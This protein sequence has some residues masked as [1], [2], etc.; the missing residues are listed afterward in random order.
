MNKGKILRSKED[1]NTLNYD[2]ELE[3]IRNE[4]RKNR[5]II[6]RSVALL[7]FL[8][9]GLISEYYYLMLLGGVAFISEKNKRKGF[10]D[11]L[12]N[13][14]G[15]A[16]AGGTLGSFFGPAGLGIGVAVGV[17]GG[18]VFTFLIDRKNENEFERVFRDSHDKDF[19]E[20]LLIN[21][22]YIKN[23]EGTWV[24][25]NRE[26]INLKNKEISATSKEAMDDVKR[27][28]FAVIAQKKK[29]EL[30]QNL[31]SV[32]YELMDKYISR[33]EKKRINVEKIERAISACL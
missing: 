18:G 16:G 30:N 26:K 1:S 6:I 11:V 28:K 12:R 20:K 8:F 10:S 21:L 27:I 3:E 31:F 32:M 14:G 25:N 22:K 4:I 33:G 9:T 24:K 29:V 5:E 23:N 7:I 13:T 2:K 15:P 19:I 17:I